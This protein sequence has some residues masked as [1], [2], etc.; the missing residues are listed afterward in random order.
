MAE[1]MWQSRLV[2]PGQFV[3]EQVDRP[4]PGP[5]E[6]LIR[7]ARVGVCGSDISAFHGR[8]PYIA[9]PI[10]LGHEFSG[11]V[12]ARGGADGPAPGAR[13]TVV[14]HLGCGACPACARGTYNLCDGLRVIGCQA[15]GAHADYVLAPAHLTVPLPDAMS[16]D[17]GAM[18]EPAAVAVHAARRAGI[19]T[20]DAVLVAGAGPIGLFTL[21]CA[22]A[23]GAR[24]VYA[25]DPVPSR[26]AL[27]LSLGADGVID[28]G[29]ESFADGLARLGADR[30]SV[31]ADCVGGG[32]AAFDALLALAPRGSRILA[33]GVLKSDARVPRL[34]DLVEHE[35]SV[36][37]TSMYVLRDYRDAIAWLSDGTLRTAGLV[38]H[39][40]PLADVSAAFDL[41]ER[42]QEPFLKIIL[43]A[44]M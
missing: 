2:A 39:T 16:W 25:A 15:P 38:T 22:R 17:D 10:V 40:L 12:A 21:Q 37:G 14:P 9:C 5:D 44:D 28:P 36:I 1:R 26:R 18:V 4:E 29:T 13:V 34:P 27:A 31:Y 11:V 7:V 35:L 3:R 20:D 43:A 41:I 30:P 19:G 23:L 6:V 32:G 33:I 8:H 42:G 24:A